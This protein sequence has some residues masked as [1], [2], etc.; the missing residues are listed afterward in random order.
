MSDLKLLNFSQIIFLKR[1]KSWADF[2]GVTG[3]VHSESRGNWVPC[4][5]GIL[6]KWN[7]LKWFQQVNHTPL[8]RRRQNA[9]VLLP[10]WLGENSSL[11]PGLAIWY[12]PELVN[13]TCHPGFCKDATSALIHSSVLFPTKL[14]FFRGTPFPLPISLLLSYVDGWYLTENDLF[15]AYPGFRRGLF[16]SHTEFY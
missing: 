15:C 12:E 5:T 13:K 16:V 9:L 8:C 1:S 3:T 10:A 7:M 4:N 11:I 2:R 14:Y 6:N